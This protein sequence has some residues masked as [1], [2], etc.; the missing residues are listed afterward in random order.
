MS[1]LKNKCTN[2]VISISWENKLTYLDSWIPSPRLKIEVGSES[3]GEKPTSLASLALRTGKW[4]LR[5]PQILRE[6]KVVG[7]IRKTILAWCSMK[8][9]SRMAYEVCPDFWNDFEFT[10][11]DQPGV[12][13]K[14][15]GS[16][17]SILSSKWAILLTIVYASVYITTG[18]S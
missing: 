3:I 17:K 4:C 8:I 2:V 18:G 12:L 16:D 1:S 15:L 14:E 11:L 13:S 9:P 10:S 6:H 7:N 5:L